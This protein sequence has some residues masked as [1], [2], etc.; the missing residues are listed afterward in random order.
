MADAA[1][2]PDA[3]IAQLGTHEGLAAAW[4]TFRAGDVLYCARDGAPIALAIDAAVGVYRFVCVRCGN[5]SPWFE[6]SPAGMRVS[7]PS[8]APPPP[9]A[10]D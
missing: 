4:E 1:K 2:P 3:G 10:D 5:A 7:A 6:S 8:V 9:I